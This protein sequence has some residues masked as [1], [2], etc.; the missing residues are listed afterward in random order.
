MGPKINTQASFLLDNNY[1]AVNVWLVKRK[2]G[3]GAV[4]ETAEAGKSPVNISL[5]LDL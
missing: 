4:R 5:H 1:R 2:D 3:K